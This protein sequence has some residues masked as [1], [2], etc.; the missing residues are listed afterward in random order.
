MPRSKPAAIPLDP[1]AVAAWRLAGQHL[2]PTAAR[3]DLETVATDLVGVQAQVTSSAALSFAIRT[4]GGRIGDLA[5]AWADRRLIRSWGMRGTLHLWAADDYPLVVAA[6]SRRETWRRPVWFRYFDVTEAEME[7]LIEAVGEIL[8]DGRP[9]TRAELAAEIGARL[10]PKQEANLGSSWGTYL[11]PAAMR[12]LLGQAAGEGNAV[13]F[14]R[15]STWLGHWR[16]VG[17]D[18]AMATVL[19]R[20][21]R[22]YGPATKQEIARWWGGATSMVNPALKAMGDELVEVEV[23]GTRALALAADLAAIREAAIPRERAILL[24]GFDPLIVGGGSRDRLI[25]AAHLPRVSRTAGWISPTVLVD[26]VVAGVWEGARKGSRYRVTI[27]PFDRPSAVTKRAI[28]RAAQR[29]AAVHGADAEIA[30]G[31]VFDAPPRAVAQ[32]RSST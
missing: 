9:R 11:K 2:V 21:I 32:A 7:A 3:D 23:N 15:P 5:A 30:Y 22:A 12:G 14:I 28:E 6:L 25:P 29:I 16:E 20:S 18:E 31:R 4:T 8:G 26:G 10:G 27:D 17:H 19:R 24:G 1:R 13:R